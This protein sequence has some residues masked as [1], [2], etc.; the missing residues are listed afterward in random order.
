MQINFS[1]LL[2]GLSAA[3][4]QTVGIMQVVPLIGGETLGYISART[5]RVSSPNY[6]IM[7]FENSAD[8]AMIVPAGVAYLTKTSHQDHATARVSVVNPRGLLIDEGAMCVESGQSGHFQNLSNHEFRLLPYTLRG[9]AHAVRS[10]HSFRKLWNAI[11]RF[12]STVGSGERSYIS[13]FYDKF[14]DEL[15]LFVAQFELV[16][17]QLGFIVLINGSVYGIERLPNYQFMRDMWKPLIKEC[18][19]G[20]VTY[21]TKKYGDFAKPATRQAM[22]GP[23]TNL[24]ELSYELERAKSNEDENTRAVFRAF[25]NE[26]AGAYV[27]GSNQMNIVSNRFVGEAVKDKDGNTVYLSM[28]RPEGA[29]KAKDPARI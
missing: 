5:A 29:F 23:I 6:G 21:M 24:E 2:S 11:S 7:K 25:A 4:I 9:E 12:N 17:D 26:S 28:I 3:R 8:Q 27:E 1:E 13:D 10:E 22:T 15:E 19:G 16:K 20:L 18:Y 14:D